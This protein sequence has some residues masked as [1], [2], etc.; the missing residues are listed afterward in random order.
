MLPDDIRPFFEGTNFGHVATLLPDGSP[1]SVAV[2]VGTL[3][4]RVTFFTQDASRK[5]RN[6]ERDPRVAISV[7]DRENPYRVAYL[8]G[9]VV[10]KRTGEAALELIDAIAQRYTGNPFPMR[11]GT[12]YVIEPERTGTMTLPF[13]PPS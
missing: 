9:R 3:G 1:H 7:I 2:W 4:D 8:R 5:A 11:S 6:L 10:E 13:E 12:V